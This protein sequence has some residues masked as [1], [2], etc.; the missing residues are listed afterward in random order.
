MRGLRSG[1]DSNKLHSWELQCLF[2]ARWWRLEERHEVSECGARQGNGHRLK[3]Q[4]EADREMEKKWRLEGRKNGAGT[5]EEGGKDPQRLRSDSLPSSIKYLTAGIRDHMEMISFWPLLVFGKFTDV[6]EARIFSTV[7]L[8][9]QALLLLAWCIC[10][11]MCTRSI[12]A[13]ILVVCVCTTVCLCTRFLALF[14]LKTMHTML[15]F[16]LLYHCFALGNDI[17]YTLQ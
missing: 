11:C 16:L 15:M 7:F 8:R 17:Q 5:E 1:N 2:E 4:R 12:T 9:L 14:G 3:T 13:A 10:V 6:P